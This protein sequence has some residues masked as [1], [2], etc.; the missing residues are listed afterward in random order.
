MNTDQ[1]KYIWTL[2]LIILSDI[3]IEKYIY[4]FFLMG[5]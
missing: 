3:F 4:L 5:N 2:A 1:N